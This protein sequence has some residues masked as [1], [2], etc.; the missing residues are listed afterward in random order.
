LAA[1]YG[2][3]DPDSGEQV[4]VASI[5]PHEGRE[6]EAKLLD[7]IFADTEDRARPRRV[8]VVASL[9]MSDGFRPIKSFLR[10][11]GMPEVADSLQTYSY[12]TKRGRYEQL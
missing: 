3:E 8:M 5:V 11:D 6:I 9:P 1:A 10:A 2:L 4:L 7:E 12:N